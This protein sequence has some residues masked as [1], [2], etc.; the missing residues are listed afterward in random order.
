MIFASE[1]LRLPFPIVANVGS[2][3][4]ARHAPNYAGEAEQAIFGGASLKSFFSLALF[5]CCLFSDAG[6]RLF[7]AARHALGVVPAL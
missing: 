3:S 6:V 7:E 2:R 5:H 1:L 4:L